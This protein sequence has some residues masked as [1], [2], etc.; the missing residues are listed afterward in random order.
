M[1]NS[2]MVGD[3]GSDSD[4]AD[5]DSDQSSVSSTSDSG[6]PVDRSAS[7]SVVCSGH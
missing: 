1:F 6:R 7:Q 2:L 5:S 4:S 3:G